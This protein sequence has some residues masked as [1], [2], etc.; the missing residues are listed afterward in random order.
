MEAI[1]RVKCPNCGAEIDV[2]AVLFHE[3]EDKMEAHYT[4]RIK[5]EREKIRQE[6][7]KESEGALK[8]LQ[9]SLKEKSAQVMELNKTK[10]ENARL[11][12]EKNELKD[13]INAEKDAELIQKLKMQ[14]E[15]QRVF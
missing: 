7:S 5:N 9:E 11:E 12:L 10:A 13:K 3:V 1:E 4:N 2:N 6:I 8:T 15:E 14:K